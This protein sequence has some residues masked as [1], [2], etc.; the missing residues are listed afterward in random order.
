MKNFEKNMKNKADSFQM[1]PLP[2]SFDKVM[3]ALEKKKKRRFIF[4]IWF[5]IPGF[6]VGATIGVY[7]VYQGIGNSTT[8]QN[9]AQE[10]F[11]NNTTPHKNNSPTYSSSKE[12]SNFPTD[13][14]NKKTID[15][16]QSSKENHINGNEK[17]FQNKSTISKN[18]Q[19]PSN[20]NLTSDNK[21]ETNTYKSSQTNV[22]TN[23]RNQ[24]N[25]SIID[26]KQKINESKIHTFSSSLVRVPVTQ[27]FSLSQKDVPLVPVLKPNLPEF[28]IAKRSKF[29]LGI[30]ADMG[31]TKS[32]FSTTVP[33]DSTF[34]GSYTG[35]RSST[36]KFMFSFS[37]GLQFRY[38]PVKFL[39]LETGI[40]F[41]RMQS[42]QILLGGGT[43]A[44][45]VGP[46]YDP[47]TAFSIS[48]YSGNPATKEFYNIYDYVSIPIK[49]FY[50]KRWSWIGFEGGGGV[51]FDIPV[52]TYSYA[53][54]ENSGIS[55]LTKTVNNSRL[56]MFGIQVAANINVVFH[57]KKFSVFGGPTFK[58]R[59]NSMFDNQYI[60]QQRPYFIG[61]QIGARYNF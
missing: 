14:T 31:V 25:N 46:T 47:D 22:I 17:S 37:T 18:T 26:V 35:I 43:S 20:K 52:N 57:I 34:K 3:A 11:A 55:Y 61:G 48:A 41:T 32:I 50:Q 29:S 54:D 33:V 2:D 60:M 7:Q 10:T 45:L 4:W 19:G 28:I 53:A 24:T 59:L 6:A 51:I 30:Y 5:L 21:E 42:Y 8:T 36:D 56:N 38:S 39:S 1:S 16:T 15:N 23:T 9:S 12:N 13:N 27:Q 40:G 49:I 58:Y 44:S